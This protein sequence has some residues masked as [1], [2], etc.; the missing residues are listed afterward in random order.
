MFRIPKSSIPVSIPQ[1]PN[2][3]RPNKD[4]EKCPTKN[5]EKADE[6]SNQILE[7]APEPGLGLGVALERFLDPDPEQDSDQRDSNPIPR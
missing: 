2:L 3:H 6:P 4:P 7:K 1:V 5:P